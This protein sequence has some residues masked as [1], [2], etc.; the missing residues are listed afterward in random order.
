MCGVRHTPLA[1]L[2]QPAPCPLLRW[3]GLAVACLLCHR[4]LPVE[5]GLGRLSWRGT[6]A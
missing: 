2:R 4:L 1:M 5:F 6:A 3:F